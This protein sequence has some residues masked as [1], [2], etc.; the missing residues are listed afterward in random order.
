MWT[1]ICV[2]Y[3]VIAVPLLSLLLAR[4]LSGSNLRSRITGELRIQI[5]LAAS[6]SESHRSVAR[7]RINRP[8]PRPPQSTDACNTLTFLTTAESPSDPYNKL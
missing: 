4:S 3:N 1:V 8:Q 2:G 5:R 7:A 6:Q